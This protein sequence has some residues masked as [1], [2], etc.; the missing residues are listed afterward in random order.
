MF[1]GGRRRVVQVDSQSALTAV[2]GHWCVPGDLVHI[3]EH[4]QLACGDSTAAQLKARQAQCLHSQHRRAVADPAEP[5]QIDIPASRY[6]RGDHNH[7]KVG[8]VM[9]VRI[10]PPPFGLHLNLSRLA[11]IQPYAHGGGPGEHMRRS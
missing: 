11:D 6:V 2:G 5:G 8:A 10:G 3:P 7:G 4:F 9:P 1:R